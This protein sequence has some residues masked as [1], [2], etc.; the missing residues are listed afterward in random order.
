M[1]RLVL[2]MATLLLWSSAAL[3]DEI[4]AGALRWT[5]DQPAAIQLQADGF[6]FNGLGYPMAGVFPLACVFDACTA[7]T[8]LDL[9]AHWM[10]TDLP[11]TAHLGDVR[12]DDIGSLASP[13]ALDAHWLGSLTA[14]PGMV[15]APFA[16]EGLLQTPAGWVDL[17]GSGLASATFAPYEG[18]LT[19]ARLD[20]VF[21]SD[22]IA[23][24][25]PATLLLMATGIVGCWR[26]RRLEGV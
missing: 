4:R 22:A 19:L 25:E 24:P 21:G 16:F 11:G 17:V 18:R 2:M 12:Y 13:V 26:M 6:T 8:L 1:R 3:A 20:Y 14:M 10:G 7:G 15:R 5:F 9:D 23:N